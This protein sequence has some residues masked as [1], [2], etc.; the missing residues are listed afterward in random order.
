VSLSRTFIS[1]GAHMSGAE[2]ARGPGAVC[3]IE[4]RLIHIEYLD[5]LSGGA[6]SAHSPDCSAARALLLASL[7]AC[8]V[9]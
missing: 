2:L 1:T 9:A 3:Q 8:I 5:Q 4:S 7:G 6:A